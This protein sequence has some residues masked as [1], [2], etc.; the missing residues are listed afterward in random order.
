MNLATPVPEHEEKSSRNPRKRSLPVVL[1]LLK[2]NNGMCYIPEL[3]KVVDSLAKFPSHEILS[4]DN[5]VKE[6]DPSIRTHTVIPSDTYLH[7]YT[8]TPT[9]SHK[10]T[11]THTHTHTHIDT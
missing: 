1:P 8:H 10:H 7:T 4:Y 5:T 2:R 6:A 3:W 9:H 11:H